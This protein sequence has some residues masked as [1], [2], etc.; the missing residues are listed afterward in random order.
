M[1]TNQTSIYGQSHSFDFT[2]KDT[3]A[4]EVMMEVFNTITELARMGVE[5]V[6]ITVEKV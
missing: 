1:I 6:K 5:N 2:T 3:Q 4:N